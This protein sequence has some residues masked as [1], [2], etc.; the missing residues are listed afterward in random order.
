MSFSM[1]RDH[2]RTGA[3]RSSTTIRLTTS[4]VL[5]LLVPLCCGCTA[6]SSPL[7]AA[8]D[9]SDRSAAAV[10]LDRTELEQ[11]HEE[12]KLHTIQLR[13]IADDLERRVANSQTVD[14]EILLRIEEQVDRASRRFERIESLLQ[15]P[16]FGPR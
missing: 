8:S 10:V 2:S 6:E 12:V 9:R 14:R 13:A 3:I 16:E 1:R 4:L 5:M 7:D 11:L 15:Q